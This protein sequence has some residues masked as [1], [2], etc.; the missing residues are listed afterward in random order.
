MASNKKV[1]IGP[2][3]SSYLG[4]GKCYNKSVDLCQTRMFKRN[5]ME[6]IHIKIILNIISLM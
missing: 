2:S 1:G 4:N 5:S 3:W 6:K